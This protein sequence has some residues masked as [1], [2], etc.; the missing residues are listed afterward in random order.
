MCAIEKVES[1][2]K[3]FAIIIRKEITNEGI[4]FVSNPEDLLQM[5]IMTHPSGY[6]I[7]PHIHKPFKRI[8]EGTQEVMFIKNGKLLVEFFDFD[9]SYISSVELKSG[10]WIVLLEGG[11]G[12]KMLEDTTF[13]EVKNGPY[14]EKEDKIKFR[15]NIKDS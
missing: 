5:G 13:I 11:H 1:N 3:I 12:F 10:D 7:I 8:T 14:V 6:E 4:N 2:G 15:Y 9:R